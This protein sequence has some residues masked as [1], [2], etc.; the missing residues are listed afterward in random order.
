VEAV[1][2]GEAPV[3][4]TGLEELI[5]SCR[6]NL[7]ATTNVGE[8]VGRSAMTFIIVPTPSDKGGAFEL[9]YV[10]KAVEA[11]G[12][13]LRGKDG[14]H[15]VVIT[16]TV[17]PGDTEARLRP[18]LEEAAGKR[19]GEGMGLC[20]NPEFIA[21]GSV[22]RDMMH[23]DFVLIG[24]SDA[25]AGEL[26]AEVHRSVCGAE[27]RVA[28]MN[29]VNAEVT[30]LSVNSFITTKITFANMLAR[31]CEKLPGAD[32]DVVTQAIGLD[33]RIGRKYLKGAVSYGGP[34]FPRDNNAFARL[35]ERLGVPTLL[36]QATDRMNGE[37]VESLAG[38]VLAHAPAEGTVGVLGLSYKPQ[39]GVCE[40]SAGLRLVQS[41]LGS[42]VRVAVYDPAALEEARRVLGE[43]VTYA[44]SARACA[45][46]SDVV[47]VCVAWPEFAGLKPS[48]LRHSGRRATVID[49]WR[50]LDRG[51]FEAAANLIVL[52]TGPV[53]EPR[54]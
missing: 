27:V 29:I 4:E 31:V 13:A 19:V 46:K 12:R 39:T 54:S 36:P 47:V 51:A 30:K 8:A 10:L 2:R 22:I 24:E 18:A 45:G 16:S 14:Y 38:L 32:G 9:G 50:V 40:A 21:L 1:N 5:R 7:S 49:C 52:G 33:T 35:G 34:C 41:L 25:K 28:R 53:R 17:M 26:L 48:D 42:Q 43:R 15:L 20:Y 23:P 44:T 11:V 37:L 3:R 6:G